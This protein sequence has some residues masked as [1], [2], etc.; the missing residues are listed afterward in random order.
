MVEYAPESGRVVVGGRSPP[1]DVV[2][3]VPRSEYRIHEY[4]EVVRGGV[5]AVE[6]DA[7][8][9]LEYPA[10]L[11]EPRAHVCEVGQHPRWAE[12]LHERDRGVVKRVRHGVLERGH[13]VCGG[14][15]PSPGVREAAHLRWRAVALPKEDVVLGV[16][17][18]GRVEVDQVNRLVRPFPHP[19]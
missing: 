1:Y 11:G 2:A 10:S 17:V 19:V 18:E 13:A 4:L 9:G 8:S 6:V 14:G 5:V 12:Q 16:A 3:K 15:I 7:A